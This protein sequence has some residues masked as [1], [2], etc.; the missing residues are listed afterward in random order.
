ML[1][2]NHPAKSYLA[3]QITTLRPIGW[4]GWDTTLDVNHGI[5]NLKGPVSQAEVKTVLFDEERMLWVRISKLAIIRTFY[6][7]L[8]CFVVDFWWLVSLVVNHPVRI[9]PF[10]LC[11]NRRV[12]IRYYCLQQGIIFIRHFMC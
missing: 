2:L 11:S 4:E 3:N 6:T 10:H 1:I 8:R 7:S 12:I 5:V 9:R